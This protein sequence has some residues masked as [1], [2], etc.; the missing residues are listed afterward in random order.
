MFYTAPEH[1]PFTMGQG[2][3]AALLIHG[4]PGTPA[5]MRPIGQAL[6]DMGWLANGILLPGL[7]K[8]ISTLPTIRRQ[9]WIQSCHAAY[10]Q[11]RKNHQKVVLV[12]H[13]MGAALAI[14]TSAETPPDA[15]ILTAPFWRMADWR[16]RFLPLL[17]YLI[18]RIHPYKTADFTRPEIRRSF[19]RMVANVNLDDPQI[20]TELRQKVALPTQA[21]NEVR[22]VGREAYKRAAKIHVSTL[23]IQ[24]L[25]DPTVLPTDTRKLVQRLGK[26]VTLQEIMGDHHIVQPYSEHYPEVTRQVVAFL[27]A[28]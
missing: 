17:P 5:E 22:L 15:L 18:P 12:G 14:H 13:S 25:Q 19:E 1:Q 23:V 7:G 4:F 6:A 28:V 20:Q 8:N 10:Q 27:A 11:L 24:G 3:C 21:L 16:A 2:D 9:D 26:N